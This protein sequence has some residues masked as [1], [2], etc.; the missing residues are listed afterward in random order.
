MS[1]LVA[2][3]VGFILISLQVVF[4]QEGYTLLGSLKVTNYTQKDYK[5]NAQIF[6][7]GQSKEGV[8]YF[9]NQ[10]GVLQYDGTEWVT[11]PLEDKAESLALVVDEDFLVVSTSGLGEFK[12]SSNGS[13]FYESLNDHLPG[14]VKDLYHIVK[15]GEFY[16]AS[17]FERLLVFDHDLK[18]I[19][20]YTN[21]D[22]NI[23]E[24]SVLE[25]GVYFRGNKGDIIKYD[26]KTFSKLIS[27]P[28]GEDNMLLNVLRFK[29]RLLVVTEQ[30]MIFELLDGNLLEVYSDPSITIKSALNID[31]EFISVGTYV[32]GVVILDQDFQPIYHVN[33]KKGL[34]DG[35]IICQ[36][37]DHEKNLW[38]GTS[39]GIS[40]V[41]LM[42]PIITYESVFNDATI[43]DIAYYQNNVIM[44]T[45][46]GAYEFLFDGELT[47]IE[48]I[49]DDCFGISQLA[50]ETD[51][52]IYVSALYDV[53]KFNGN[54]AESI[55]QGGPY[56]V[57]K[58]PLDANNLIVLHYDG[59]QLL[60]YQKGRFVELN[61]IFNFSDG[62]PFNFIVTSKGDIWIG[63]KP[64]DGIYKINVSELQNKEV[65]FTRFY[66]NEGLPVGQ[67][68]LFEYESSIFVAT[69][70]GVYK[71]IAGQ[72]EPYSG[73]GVDFT[74]TGQGV[75]RI[76]ADPMGN[77]WMVL[78]ND[79]ENTYE[80]GYSCKEEGYKWHSEFFK[81]YDEY[82]VHVIHHQNKDVTWLGGPGGL[83]S[84]DK[85]RVSIH[86]TDFQA[87]VRSVKFGEEILFGGNGEL[88]AD[89]N[90]DYNSKLKIEFKFAANTFFAEDKTLYSWK[91]EGFDEDWSE[92]SLETV[93]DYALPEG[94]YTFRVRAMN[95]VGEISEEASFSFM[96]MPPWYRTWWAYVLFAL[97]LVLVVWV[98]IRMSISRVKQQN[99]RL[100]KI[101][102]ERTQE[103]VAQKAEAEKQ[104][105]IAEHQKHL[106]EE[107]NLEILDSI[108]YAE[109]I[110]RSFLAT[111]EILDENLGDYFVF[112]RPKD[113]VS[114]D[115]YWAG[116]LNN[117]NFA[118]TVADSTGHGVPGAIMSLLNITS[119]EKSIETEVEP[120]LILGKTR[121]IIIER[122]KKDG[123]AEGG[124]DGM[125]CN[126][127]VLNKEK[128]ELTFASAHNPIVI[129]RNGEILEYKGDKMPVGKHDRQNESFTKNSFELQKGDMIYAL[130]DGF[131]DQFGGPKGK[132]YMI[133]NLKQL[134]LDISSLTLSEQEQKLSIEF[135]SWKEGH[136]QIDDVCI[137]GVRV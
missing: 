82:I 33:T 35:T 67:T 16:V 101:V 91:L 124:K 28:F 53:Y 86:T 103:V 19:D 69:D 117:G 32:D 116:H 75:H 115:F 43:E 30:G 57:A 17:N 104:R 108:N 136:E 20:E 2:F 111:K 120:H 18:L 126:L 113:V 62:E 27:N 88:S 132:K 96:V 8:M 25:D 84:F 94:M 128:S 24:L 1:K 50:F 64:N 39:N 41:D 4:A 48:G 70:Y 133:K 12:I 31:N 98:I 49:N 71:Y 56:M 54:K 7:I 3:F 130:T 65:S 11:L 68:Y 52:S 29:D 118:F 66:V 38:L 131:P 114:G 26:G 72:F 46:G 89:Y 93:E 45:G 61:Y 95:T 58:S 129:I 6:F 110:Q 78:F 44:A 80:I 81:G 83:M 102:E 105:D 14:N 99:I 92:W 23:G 42:S 34:N 77:V 109:R 107:K 97:I 47:K 55:T 36:F 40:K 87:M 22:K 127:L 74:K 79:Q 21:A 106:V 135:N 5:A 59:I 119:L 100:E 85:T 90:L 63:T 73:F 51:T 125:D 60:E 137:I 9:A 112:F 15:Y 134:F 122:L 13:L 37:I 123:S 76:N 121:E 10:R